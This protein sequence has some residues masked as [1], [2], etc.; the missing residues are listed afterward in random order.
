MFLTRGDSHKSEPTCASKKQDAIGAM[1]ADDLVSIKDRDTMKSAL[2]FIETDI[3]SRN[4]KCYFPRS[5]GLKP[6]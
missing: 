6:I 5:K 4:F 2:T 1:R 3:N